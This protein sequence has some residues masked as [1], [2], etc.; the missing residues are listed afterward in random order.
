MRLTGKTYL[1]YQRM[2]ELKSDSDG[3][4]TTFLMDVYRTLGQ[5]VR[6]KAASWKQ[7]A[8][9]ADTMIQDGLIKWNISRLQ[10]GAD[11]EEYYW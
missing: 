6:V 4:E 8:G 9:I 10:T 1:T 5:T 2:Q 3:K 11:G 7:T